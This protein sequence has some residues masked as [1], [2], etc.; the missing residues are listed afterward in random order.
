MIRSSVERRKAN[1]N[2]HPKLSRSAKGLAPRSEAETLGPKTIRTSQTLRGRGAYRTTL[3]AAV[4]PQTTNKKRI[5]TIGPRRVR[6]WRGAY[7]A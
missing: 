5:S 3:T 1:A 4:A 7:H 6:V 2:N